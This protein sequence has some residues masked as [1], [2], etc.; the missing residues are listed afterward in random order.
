MAVGHGAGDDVSDLIH[1]MEMAGLRC[2]V[3]QNDLCG[4]KIPL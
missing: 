1:R 2:V 4:T 3:E